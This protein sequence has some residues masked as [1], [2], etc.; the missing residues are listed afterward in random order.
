MFKCN[1]KQNEYY[2]IIFS[3]CWINSK[4]K[5]QKIFIFYDYLRYTYW[6]AMYVIMITM[7]IVA[8]TMLLATYGAIM[9]A[10]FALGSR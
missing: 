4:F 6:Y 8:P 10:S 3:K 9:E 5:I 1:F 7:V 2:E